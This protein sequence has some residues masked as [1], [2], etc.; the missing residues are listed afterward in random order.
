MLYTVLLQPGGLPLSMP[1][2]VGEI[3]DSK[4]NPL[5]VIFLIKCFARSIFKWFS[6][7]FF[8]TARLKGGMQGTCVGCS[9]S[10]HH[11]PG[12]G[13]KVRKQGPNIKEEDDINQND[14]YT[15]LSES[16]R[17]LAMAI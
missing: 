16:C 8:D 4:M 10:Q 15:L 11:H 1:A 9:H 13:R 17:A 2:V 3:F 6:F 5:P 14:I 12:H 7:N